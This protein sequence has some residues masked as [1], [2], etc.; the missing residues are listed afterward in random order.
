MVHRA[1]RSLQKVWNFGSAKKKA[2]LMSIFQDSSGLARMHLP[3]ESLV[4][5]AVGIS[6]QPTARVHL[7]DS[8]VHLLTRF[9]DFCRNSTVE[10]TWKISTSRDLRDLLGFA[11][12]QNLKI[13]VSTVSTVSKDFYD[14]EVHKVRVRT[15]LKQLLEPRIFLKDAVR[16]FRS[17]RLVWH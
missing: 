2:N 4:A 7:S 12:L 16:L 8:K 1:A 9:E 17:V 10:S 3:Q 13:P 11:V 14:P 6:N 5:E 15:E